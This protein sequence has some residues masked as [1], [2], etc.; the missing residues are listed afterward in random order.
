MHLV[1]NI[2]GVLQAGVD[3]RAAGGGEETRAGAADVS[4]RAP[5]EARGSVP[6]DLSLLTAAVVQRTSAREGN[7]RL[8]S[9]NVYYKIREEGIAVL[10]QLAARGYRVEI[11]TERMPYDEFIAKCG[12]AWL[13]WSPEG[14]GWECYRHYEACIAGSIPLMN[15]PRI[16]CHM[17]LQDRVHA[18][19]YCFQTGNMLDTIEEAL[20]DKERLVSMIQRARL[21]VR[22]HHTLEGLARYIID[23]LEDDS[24]SARYGPLLPP[25]ADAK[26]L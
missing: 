11:S 24:L 19:Y 17:P 12:S 4:G 10:N 14:F 23:S 1:S 21:F 16:E 9:G 13:V 22:E 25:I 6:T 8:L 26:T 15:Y 5:A 20:A 3:A 18:F 2:Q 7:R